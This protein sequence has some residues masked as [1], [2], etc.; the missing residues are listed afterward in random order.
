MNSKLYNL[1]QNNKKFIYIYSI[2]LSVI[3]ISL[4]VLSLLGNIERTAYLSEFHQVSNNNYDC[5][6]NYYGN[7]V[8]RHSDIYGVY[9][10]FKQETEYEIIEENLGRPFISLISDKDLKENDK[11]DVQYKLKLKLP[12]IMY[13]LA[14][15]IIIPLIYFKCIKKSYV[16]LILINTSLY[17]IILLF[18][19]PLFSLIN[20]KFSAHDILFTNLFVIIAYILFNN[21]LLPT[22][23]FILVNIFSFFIIEPIALTYQNTI[24][25]ITDIPILYSTL[26][27]VISLGLK[28]IT[29]TVTF[30]YFAIIIYL[31][32]LMIMNLMKMNRKK[33]IVL[34][35][36]ILISAYF[37]FFFIF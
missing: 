17:Y 11:I 6:I 8:F 35:S 36:L 14:F 20:L 33:S 3:V 29:I 1:F 27:E 22:S 25:L 26:L 37:I 30:I 24:L 23:L 4:L 32:V 10:Y 31:L 28:I 19:L 12:L 21:K 9:P 15:L 13:I 16:I 7:K 18:I 34:I 5:K 2:I